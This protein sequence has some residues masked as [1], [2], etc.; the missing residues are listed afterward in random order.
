MLAGFTPAAIDEMD[1]DR[2]QRL[3]WALYVRGLDAWR[4][5]PFLTK[6]GH[7]SIDVEM[8]PPESAARR[9]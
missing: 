6:A 1:P 2:R 4:M 3:L 9:N 5:N 7:A 8:Y